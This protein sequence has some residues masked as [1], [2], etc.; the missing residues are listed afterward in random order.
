MSASNQDFEWGPDII[1]IAKAVGK[2]YL[3]LFGKE[4]SLDDPEEKQ[5]LDVFSGELIHKFCE[6]LQNI[7][8]ELFSKYNVDDMSAL[9]VKTAN[10]T[11]KT[12]QEQKIVNMA[13]EWIESIDP[14]QFKRNT[15]QTA[16][17]VANDIRKHLVQ[18]NADSSHGGI[19]GLILVV[20]FIIILFVLI[21]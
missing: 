12:D 2:L 15:L 1:K 19:F 9:I 5:M 11:Q 17:N 6:N 20:V 21:A 13:I 14:Y 16:Q 4:L 18:K 8:P 10:K 7:E 3:P